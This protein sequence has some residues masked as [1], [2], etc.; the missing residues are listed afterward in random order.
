MN[1]VNSLRYLTLFVVVLLALYMILTMY[2]AGRSLALLR[3]LTPQASRTQIRAYM[4][5]LAI[6]GSILVL[7]VFVLGIL[8]IAN[9]NRTTDPASHLLISVLFGL[10]ILITAMSFATYLNIKDVHQ[11]SPLELRRKTNAAASTARWATFSSIAGISVAFLVLLM[12]SAES[13][14]EKKLI[15]MRILL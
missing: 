5:P 3:Y 2:F 9:K 11:V 1:V 10:T 15:P 7:V 14:H 4:L 8:M 12:L 13:Q 6:V